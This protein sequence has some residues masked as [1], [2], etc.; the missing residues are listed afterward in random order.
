VGLRIHVLRTQP[1]VG[2]GLHGRRPAYHLPPKSTR[3]ERDTR[4]KMQ[5]EGHVGPRV[6]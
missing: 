3:D 5:C 6:G 4:G 1:F 2:R